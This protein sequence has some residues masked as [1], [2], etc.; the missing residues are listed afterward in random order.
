MS[1]RPTAKLPKSPSANPLRTRLDLAR[2]A[3][4][5]VAFWTGALMSSRIALLAGFLVITGCKDIRV[6]SGEIPDEYLSAASS[7]L[8]TYT[9][10][11]NHSAASLHL[12]LEGR[13]VVVS[14]RSLGGSDLLDPRCESRIGDLLRVHGVVRADGSYQ[15][16]D[17]VFAFDPNRC[18]SRV[19][20]RELAL[21]F[22][23]GRVDASLLLHRGPGAAGSCHIEPGNVRGGQRPHEVCSKDESAV[24]ER[25]YFRKQN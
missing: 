3:C 9:G 18:W 7:Y 1:S 17:A 16:T 6:V 4:A 21:S 5:G 15:V 10:V 14:Y 24:S 23:D 19:E 8:G 25:G 22:R 2:I 12:S 20:G 11:M 13:R